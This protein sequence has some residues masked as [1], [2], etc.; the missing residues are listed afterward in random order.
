MLTAFVNLSVTNNTCF[1][2]T[3]GLMYSILSSVVESGCAA[4][5]TFLFFDYKF[6]QPIYFTI[7]SPIIVMFYFGKL[8]LLESE[9]E[10]KNVCIQA[11]FPF[12]IA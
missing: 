9:F 3:N 4:V 1:F 5:L 8:L 7:E 11:A 2:L 12:W 10:H 6:S